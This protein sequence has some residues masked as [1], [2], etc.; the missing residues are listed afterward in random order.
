MS[1]QP[2][3]KRKE[4]IAQKMA[5]A[6]AR[7]EA[8]AKKVIAHNDALREENAKLLQSSAEAKKRIAELEKRNAAAEQQARSMVETANRV[9]TENGEFKKLLEE[10]DVKISAITA[11]LAK[12]NKS[13]DEQTS[14]VLRMA[15]IL[16]ESEHESDKIRS[17]F[18]ALKM[19][20][21]EAKDAIAAMEQEAGSYASIIAHR[22]DV[23]NARAEEIR[24]IMKECENEKELNRKHAGRIAEMSAT[25]EEYK[26][27]LSH[28][29][30]RNGNNSPSLFSQEESGDLVERIKD[31]VKKIDN[32][33]AV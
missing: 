1:D 6:V 33:L 14:E 8:G 21:D 5:D 10:Q 24:L 7:V 26:M 16:S 28:I 13:L 11:E 17:G 9:S 15:D 29:G 30:E 4:T 20:Y 19:Q 23:L 3:E 31:I 22:D 25:L 12:A 2:I 32:Y 18:D 27:E